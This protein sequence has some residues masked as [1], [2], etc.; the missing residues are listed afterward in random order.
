MTKI[1]KL[2]KKIPK[3]FFLKGKKQFSFKKKEK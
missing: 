1:I 2:K 3:Q